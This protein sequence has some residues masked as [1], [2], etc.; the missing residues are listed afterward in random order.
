MKELEFEKSYRGVERLVQ[1][2]I[3]ALLDLGSMIIVALNA[4]RPKSYSEIGFILRDLNILS[5]EDANLLKTLSGLRNILIQGYAII[6]RERIIEFSRR[7]RSDSIRI[8]YKLLSNIESLVDLASQELVDVVENIK[9][10]LIGNVFTSLFFGSRVKDHILKG[11][12]DIAVYMIRDC[13]F[14]ELGML[15]IDLAHALSV[16]EEN[17]DILC[18]NV[19]LPELIYEAL[20]VVP[21]IVEDPELAFT[22]KYKALLEL[23]DLEE[24]TRLIYKT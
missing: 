7:L 13:D 14:Y 9:N 17:V 22:L 5:N 15:V 8:A 18:F 23:L 16:S 20:S 12:Y 19:S 1:L 10:V 24:T 4:P 3:Q 6:N 11:D 2:K 21:V